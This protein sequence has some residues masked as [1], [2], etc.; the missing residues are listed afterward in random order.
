MLL[1]L[2]TLQLY[3]Y[4]FLFITYAC[5]GLVTCVHGYVRGVGICGYP[6]EINSHWPSITQW[7]VHGC[8]YGNKSRQLEF[9]VLHSTAVMDDSPVLIRRPFYCF[10]ASEQRRSRRRMVCYRK[11]NGFII[12]E[13]VSLYA[14]SIS[15]CFCSSVIF[16]PI[17]LG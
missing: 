14:V 5:V 9:I 16:L 2:I 1:M 6:L 4:M 11:R 8:L 15:F 10:T 12:L 13:K 17:I 7:C 3:I